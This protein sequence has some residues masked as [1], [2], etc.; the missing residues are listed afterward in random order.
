LL[1]D[2]FTPTGVPLFYPSRLTARVP[3]VK[4]GGLLEKL[5]VFPALCVGVVYLIGYT[6]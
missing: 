1:F 6:L 2:L 3:L 4:T 5:V